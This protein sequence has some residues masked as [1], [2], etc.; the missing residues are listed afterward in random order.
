MRLAHLA[1]GLAVPALATG[2]TVSG[3]DET[4]T[5]LPVTGEA[6]VV[7]ARDHVDLGPASVR[8]PSPRR[9]DSCRGNSRFVRA[10]ADFGGSRVSLTLETGG[11]GGSRVAYVCRGDRVPLGQDGAAVPL[12]GCDREELGGGRVLFTGTHAGHQ[13][14]SRRIA[15]LYDRGLRYT[16]TTGV[17]SE[18]RGYELAEI[19]QD[20][21]VGA[22]VDAA[23][24]V[25]GR[26]LP[27]PRAH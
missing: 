12:E 1:A 6:L 7:L 20:P 10:D 14:P 27:R 13:R 26:D 16:V 2:C 22:T 8:T 19:A 21:K 23:Y 17:E 24:V 3:V 4:G 5:P 25:A 9:D 15:V 11:C 18:V